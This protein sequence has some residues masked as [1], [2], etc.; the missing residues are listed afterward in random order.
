MRNRE[1]KVQPGGITRQFSEEETS[2]LV[3]NWLKAFGK[4][5]RGVNSKDFLWRIFSAG[6]YPSIG[7]IK[8]L[9]KYQQQ[10]AFEY[11][12]LSND[13]KIAFVTNLLPETCSLFDYYVFPPNLAWTMAFTHEDGWLGPYFAFHSQFEELNQVNHARLRKAQ[14][15][16]A[17]RLKGWW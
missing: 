10:Q 2:T 5:R 9:E 1:L 4:D 8:A 14:E 3:D 16:E 6:R 12:V 7:G 11:I 13:R 15:A 17:A